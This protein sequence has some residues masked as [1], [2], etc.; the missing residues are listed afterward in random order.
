MAS[1]D[2]EMDDLFMTEKEGGEENTW[3]DVWMGSLMDVDRSTEV[4]MCMV[5]EDEAMEEQDRDVDFM[6]WPVEELR[7]MHVEDK[8]IDT[9]S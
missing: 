3:L 1:L 6:T 7:E 2:L 8:V 4:S 5:K 9:I